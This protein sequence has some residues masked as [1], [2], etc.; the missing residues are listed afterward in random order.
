MT[1]N[2]RCV[3][4]FFGVSNKPWTCPLRDGSRIITDGTCVARRVGVI[5]IMVEALLPMTEEVL[6]G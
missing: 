6:F 5:I 2:E 1:W 3:A 4:G